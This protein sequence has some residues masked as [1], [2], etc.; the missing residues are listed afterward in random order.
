MRIREKGSVFV[1]YVTFIF[2]WISIIKLFSALINN[3]SSIITVVLSVEL[4][5]GEYGGEV[6]SYY[7]KT[8][9]ESFITD[10][11]LLGIILSIFYILFRTFRS[12]SGELYVEKEAYFFAGLGIFCI[13]LM[14]LFSDL[15]YVYISARTWA[16]TIVFSNIFLSFIP[17]VLI[18]LLQLLLSFILI[19]KSGF[20]LKKD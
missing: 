9:I 5:T 12:K 6:S 19:K 10:L 4:T 13:F 17:I 2:I 15:N 11:I 7:Y 1:A 20:I 8:F 14:T 16:S 18:L 3:L